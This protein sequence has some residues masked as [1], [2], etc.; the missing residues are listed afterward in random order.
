[1]GQ[2]G[3]GSEAIR[4][5]IFDDMRAETVNPSTEMT[6]VGRLC[7]LVEYDN[8]GAQAAMRV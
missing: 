2:E 1:M 4:L 5:G 3:E 7:D 8:S 6:A